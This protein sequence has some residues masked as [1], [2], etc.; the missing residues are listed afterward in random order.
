MGKVGTCD[1]QCAFVLQNLCQGLA[2][3]RA[4]DY[5][6]RA[7]DDR[8]NLRLRK[9]DLYERHYHFDGV[10]TRMED[11]SKYTIAGICG[12]ELGDDFSFYRGD[13]ERRAESCARME[14][15]FFKPWCRVI[16]SQDYDHVILF[17]LN[18]LKRIGTYLAGIDV[19]RM[20]DDNGHTSF[21]LAGIA[22]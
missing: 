13:A 11:L 19:A 14:R 16:C 8:N 6:R 20:R 7:N 4:H 22:S 17:V 10:F 15:N 9:D 5:V 18:L 21:G 3:A 12:Y 1:N 2:E